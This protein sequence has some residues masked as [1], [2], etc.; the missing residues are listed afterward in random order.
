MKKFGMSKRQQGICNVEGLYR[1]TTEAKLRILSQCRQVIQPLLGSGKL[2]CRST[3]W[4]PDLHSENIFVDPNEPGRITGIIDWQA[5]HLK[6]LFLQVRNPS[7]LDVDGPTTEGLS[8]LGLP[9]NFNDLSAEEQLAAKELRAAQSLLKLWEIDLYRNAP[10]AYQALRMRPTFRVQILGLMGSIFDDGD[11]ILEGLLITLQ[12]KWVE[13]TTRLDGQEI[14][15]CPLS[16]S[17][18]DR[19]RQAKDQAM[20]EEGVKLKAETIDALGAYTGWDGAVPNAEY[21]EMKHRLDRV[22]KDFLDHIMLQEDQRLEWGKAWP[23][24]EADWSSVR[25]CCTQPLPC[26]YVNA[27]LMFPS[28]CSSHCRRLRPSRG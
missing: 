20:W 23:F 12:D 10:G 6:P 21:E 3:M 1:P 4:H 27:D 7:L 8:L 5:V 11:P 15:P 28:F 9:E 14:P 2:D 25:L 22:R 24:T 13:A 26:T 18:E 17:A 16:F 19:S